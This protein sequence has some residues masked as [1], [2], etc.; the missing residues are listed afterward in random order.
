VESDSKAMAILKEWLG[1]FCIAKRKAE[2]DSAEIQGQALG[3]YSALVILIF[4]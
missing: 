1:W 3:R 2:E 4:Y